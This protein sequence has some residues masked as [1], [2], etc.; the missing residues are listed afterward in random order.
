MMAAE[1]PKLETTTNYWITLVNSWLASRSTDIAFD[2][3]SHCATILTCQK[4]RPKS[5]KVKQHNN[6]TGASRTALHVCIKDPETQDAQQ[7][8]Y[9]TTQETVNH[10]IG[11]RTLEAD[12]RILKEELTSDKPTPQETRIITVILGQI[13]K[14]IE[15]ILNLDKATLPDFRKTEKEWTTVVAKVSEVKTMTQLGRGWK[16]ALE[17][18]QEDIKNA[19]GTGTINP[20]MSQRTECNDLLA[21]V[22]GFWETLESVGITQEMAKE[23][24]I[25]IITILATTTAI[26]MVTVIQVLRL[27]R[28][29]R[30]VRKTIVLRMDKKKQEVHP[31]RH[32]MDIEDIQT[33]IKFWNKEKDKINMTR[34]QRKQ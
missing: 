16:E 23:V 25:T 22:D 7:A 12:L 18:T 14:S 1:M 5:I 9:R 2:T 30:R 19:I 11:N 26:A 33:Q 15:D 6:C 13:K 28:M 21:W 8:G 31:G 17:N 4:E 10:M 32:K 34:Q 20:S 27:T 3:I 24:R 29:M